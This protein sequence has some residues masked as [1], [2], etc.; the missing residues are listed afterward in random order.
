MGIW[1]RG[2][3]WG[4]CGALSSPSFRIRAVD[5]EMCRE[6]WGLMAIRAPHLT[7]PAASTV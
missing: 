5:R 7:P 3:Q 2:Q 4:G 6:I 1:V